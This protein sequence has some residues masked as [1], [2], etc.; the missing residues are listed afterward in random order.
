MLCVIHPCSCAANI[1]TPR[2][3]KVLSTLLAAYQDEKIKEIEQSIQDGQ[4]GNVT[5][6]G[7]EET[8]R[9]S[10]KDVAANELRENVKK[11]MSYSTH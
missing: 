9:Q 1:L 5:L 11:G 8:L 7:V 6:A 4:A 2:E 3:L 10:G